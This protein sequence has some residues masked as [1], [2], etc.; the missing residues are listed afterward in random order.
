MAKCIECRYEGPYSF[1]TDQNVTF[2]LKGGVAQDKMKYMKCQA[3]GGGPTQDPISFRE[4]FTVDEPCDF[5][6]PKE[7]PKPAKNDSS[8][9]SKLFGLLGGKKSHDVKFKEKSKQGPHTYK[10][11][12]GQ[13]KDSALE[14][15]RS[16]SVTKNFY[17]IIVETPDGN[18]GLDINGIYQEK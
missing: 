4:A 8:F 13:S 17:Y 7:K 18:W 15:L 1:H 16:Q 3:P 2:V 11:Y 12:V 9:L 5:F 6:Q 10:I 14:F